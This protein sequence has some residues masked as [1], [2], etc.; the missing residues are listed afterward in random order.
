M[1]PTGHIRERSP[2]SWE[3]RYSLGRDSATGKRRIATS[4]LRGN[5]R[6]AEK[7][8]R[9]LLRTLDLNEHVE[10]GRMTVQ[11]WL[12]G[13][14]GAIRQEVSPKTLERY[15]EIV[16]NFLVAELGALPIAK[17]APAHISAAYTRWATEGRKDGKPGGLS[18]QTRRH[19]HLV[20]RAA[21]SRAVEQQVIARNPAD[22]FK[23]RLPKVE[24]H[25][26]RH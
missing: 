22:V 10:P 1:R 4:T 25:I 3:L 18:P 21:L 16:R 26:P 7:E 24:R 2:G 20:L 12:T 15:G 8:L 11:D 17:L 6:D 14:L 13:W 19:I 9:R 5:R 23:K